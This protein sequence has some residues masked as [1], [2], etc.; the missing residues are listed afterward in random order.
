MCSSTCW[1]QWTLVDAELD[2]CT[3]L[4][5]TARRSDLGCAQR[6]PGRKAEGAAERS[7]RRKW[8]MAQEARA[9]RG[10]RHEVRVG[11]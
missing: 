11:A 10:A 5:A 8:H 1:P 6:E 2:A 9:A 3:K 7:A 4:D